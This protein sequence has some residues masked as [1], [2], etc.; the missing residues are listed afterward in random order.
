[1]GM[2][3]TEPVGAAPEATP[4][5]LTELSGIVAGVAGVVGVVGVGGVVGVV[6]VEEPADASRQHEGGEQ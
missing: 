3:L 4:G 6:G 5:A 1:M 2:V